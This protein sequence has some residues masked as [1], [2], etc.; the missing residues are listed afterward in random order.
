[1]DD[2]DFDLWLTELISAV[3]ESYGRKPPSPMGVALWKGVLAPMQEDRRLIASLFS[4]HAQSDD[5][6][7]LPT[8][9]H[10]LQLWR[11]NTAD[12]SQL[13]WSRV[14]QTME[15]V[16]AYKSVVF[17][18]PAI[19]CAVTDLGGWPTIC[20]S[21]L[22][23]LQWIQKRFIESYKAHAKAG[24]PHSGKLIGISEQRNAALGYPDVIQPPIMVG[25]ARSCQRV[26]ESGTSF[27]SQPI[28]AN[29]QDLMKQ[30]VDRSFESEN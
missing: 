26:L 13:A 12:H 22:E 5:G 20:Q 16:G 14:L 6:K 17:D 1:M 19:H 21:N 24:S 10:I 18:D 28:M 27:K 23:E 11:G 15:R 29:M 30:I 9:A 25:D 3:H 8:H 2:D 4:R 7:F